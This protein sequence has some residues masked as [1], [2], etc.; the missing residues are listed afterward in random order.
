[1][2]RFAVFEYQ[3]GQ[4]QTGPFLCPAGRPGPMGCQTVVPPW[5]YPYR[6]QASD[7]ILNLSSSGFH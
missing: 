1:M 5:I 2:N 4:F 3:K 7:A 6:Y